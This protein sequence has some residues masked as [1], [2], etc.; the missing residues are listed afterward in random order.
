MCDG[1]ARPYRSPRVFGD[2]SG[3]KVGDKF[4]DS[5]NS[6]PNLVINLVKNSSQLQFITTFVTNFVTKFFTKF[7]DSLNSSP[8]LVIN[9]VTNSSQNTLGLL[10]QRDGKRNCKGSTSRRRPLL[11]TKGIARPA[12]L[13]LQRALC[14][15]ISTLSAR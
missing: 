13:C 5:L 11:K 4:G 1:S 10:V 7:G 9:W 8:N 12:L 3:D 2:K 6:S 15:N 14:S